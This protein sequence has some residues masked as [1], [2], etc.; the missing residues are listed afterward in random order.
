MISEQ[1][2]VVE[3]ILKVLSEHESK[4]GSNYVTFPLVGTNLRINVLTNKGLELLGQE[5]FLGSIKIKQLEMQ[6]I[7]LI[8]ALEYIAD[9]GEFDSK[10]EAALNA[11]LSLESLKSGWQ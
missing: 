10:T 3:H 7:T 1:Q 11:I 9:I 6:L 4:F 2:R 5:G 8:H